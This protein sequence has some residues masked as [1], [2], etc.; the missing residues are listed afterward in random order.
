MSVVSSSSRSGPLRAPVFVA[1]AAPAFAPAALPASRGGPPAPAVSS[2]DVAPAR[3]PR[4]GGAAGAAGA[5]GAAAAGAA[6]A[7]GAPAAG[8]GAPAPLVVSTA[9]SSSS[10][11][12]IA[13]SGGAG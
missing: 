1:A 9:G 7:A 5:P 10:G 3:A 6:G 8:L 2:R 12:G 13:R 4:A 11:G